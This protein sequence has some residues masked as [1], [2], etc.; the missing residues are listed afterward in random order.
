MPPFLK[1]DDRQYVR[2][3]QSNALLNTDRSALL[4]ARA[5][6]ATAHHAE[7]LQDEVA[8]LRQHVQQLT[9]LV[10]QLLMAKTP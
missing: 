10:E 2:D 5:A 9:T 7:R 8:E 3:P 1:T 6:R 4:R